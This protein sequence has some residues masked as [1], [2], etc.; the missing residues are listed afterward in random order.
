MPKIESAKITWHKKA[1]E[2]LD[3]RTHDGLI[4]MAMDIGNKARDNAPWITS[5]LKNSIRWTYDDK[6]V[7]VIAG[8]TIGSTD[9]TLVTP[10]KRSVP[11]AAKR[12]RGPNR[13]PTTE[14]YMKNAFDEVMRSDWQKKY[15]GDITK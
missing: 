3:K 10:I 7:W 14:H 8:G 1:F 6:A 12:E 15:F 5:A 2:T 9:H 13:D 11:Y 4:S